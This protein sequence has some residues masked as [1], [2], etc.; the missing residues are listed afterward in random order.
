MPN[1]THR[2]HSGARR[3]GAGVPYLWSGAA[4][5]YYNAIV[6]PIFPP[7]LL[8]MSNM[9]HFPSRCTTRQCEATRK[10]LRFLAHLPTT[11]S[12]KLAE[13]SLTALLPPESLTPFADELGQ[14]ERRRRKRAA[15]ERRVAAREAAE[16][17]AAA[18]ARR[19]PSLQELRAMPALRPSGSSNA[20]E[21]ASSSV[22]A[23]REGGAGASAPAQTKSEDLALQLAIAASLVDTPAGPELPGGGVGWARLVK[24]GYAATGPSLGSSLQSAGISSQQPAGVWGGKKGSIAM[25]AASG[26]SNS[27][28]NSSSASPITASNAGDTDGGA[29]SSSKAKSKKGTL[30]F[31]T[32]QRKY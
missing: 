4:G 12:F 2:Y 16:I 29:S 5:S 17:K 20:A 9:A 28:P 14:R 31:S 30:L 15:E 26:A 22:S 18:D 25:A 13:V 23:V 10:R 21:A 27:L 11:A 24:L 19:G 6:S 1:N 32:S 8:F 7:N 3:C